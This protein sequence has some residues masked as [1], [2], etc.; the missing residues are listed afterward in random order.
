MANEYLLKKKTRPKRERPHV[1]VIFCLFSG[2]VVL[3]LAKEHNV[4]VSWIRLIT[5]TCRLEIY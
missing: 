2:Q 4:S 1:T 5:L 3:D